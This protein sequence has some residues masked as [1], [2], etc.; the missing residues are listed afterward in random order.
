M[1]KCLHDP[2]HTHTHTN[3]LSFLLL[4]SLAAS[5][6]LNSVISFSNLSMEDLSSSASSRLMPGGGGGGMSTCVCVCVCVCVE[7]HHS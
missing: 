1:D 7:L 2:L 6:A 3:S 4:S 5:S